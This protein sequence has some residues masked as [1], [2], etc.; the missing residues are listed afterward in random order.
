MDTSELVAPFSAQ[1]YKIEAIKRLR[2]YCEV[3]YGAAPGLKEAK[4]FIESLAAESHYKTV[5]KDRV[6]SV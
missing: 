3:T 6:G 4:E 5:V 2:R 1:L